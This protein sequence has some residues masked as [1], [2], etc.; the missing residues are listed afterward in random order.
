[1]WNDLLKL[2]DDRAQNN[3]LLAFLSEYDTIQLLFS[4]IFLTLEIDFL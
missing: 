2:S 3:Y 1:M 4:V